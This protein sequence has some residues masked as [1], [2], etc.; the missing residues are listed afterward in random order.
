MK[1]TS[2]TLACLALAMPVQDAPAAEPAIVSHL[3]LILFENPGT[4]GDGVAFVGHRS[5]MAA[6]L[7]QGAFSVRFADR[8]ADGSNA[9]FQ[10]AMLRYAFEGAR[11]DAKLVSEDRLPG[12]VNL[13]LGNSPDGWA[14]GLSSWRQVRY[15]GLYDGVD[16]VVHGANGVFTYDLA[17]QPGVDPSVVRIRVEGADALFVDDAG[18]LIARTANGEMRQSL[19]VTWEL[20]EDGSRRPVESSF[21][22]HADGSYGFSVAADPSS[23]LLIDPGLTWSTYLGGGNQDGSGNEHGCGVDVD[24]DC[25]AYV[26]GDTL[27]L[28]F[29][30]TPGAFQTVQGGNV[31]AFVAK[32]VGKGDALLYSTFI[33]GSGGDFG[34]GIAVDQALCAYVT[35]GT[36]SANLPV[37]GGVFDT[38]YNGNGDMFVAKLTPDGTGLSYC[39]YIGG[40]DVDASLG[41]HGIEVNA[42]GEAFITGE[43]GSADYPTTVG[44]FAT[45]HGGGFRDVF[46]TKLAAD[47]S[48]LLYSTFVGGNGPGISDSGTSIALDNA[49]NAYVVGLTTSQNFPTT[50]GVVAPNPPGNGSNG[51]LFKVSPTGAA[52]SYS[53]F[54]GGTGDVA[55]SVSVEPSTGV[56]YAVGFTASTVFPTTPGAFD[57]SSNGFGDGWITVL[58]PNAA[59][60]VYSSYLGGADV[61]LGNAVDVDAKGQAY[62]SGWTQSSNFPTT[63]NAF[64]KT[65]HYNGPFPSGSAGQSGAED[66][67][68][69]RVSADGSKIEY[70]TY[71]G[72]D[73]IDVAYAINV[74]DEGS[75]YIAGGTR[76][77][78]FPTTAGAVDTTYNGVNGDQDV[79][80]ILMPAGETV[81]PA[82][83]TSSNYGAGKPGKYGVPSLTMAAEAKVGQFG[84]AMLSN[85]SE[86]SPYAILIGN[87]TQN[88]A[89]NGGTILVQ[90]FYAVVGV[91]DG[92]GNA[93]FSYVLQE[94]PNFCGTTLYAQAFVND[95]TVFL[96]SMSSGLSMTLGY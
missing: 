59:S 54:I 48:A 96:F 31:D 42:I 75:V 9:E 7:E 4:L 36:S 26:A 33:G 84:T 56:G 27:S 5:G 91:T 81:C 88:L 62:I 49:G 92:S 21:V 25:A 38:T 61:D 68:L 2:F 20:G 58:D 83:A 51:F 73:G 65:H 71:I 47:G 19:P 41:A 16:V 89:F 80:L 53:T 50:A 12:T 46:A 90:P 87:Q 17:V 77:T 74:H 70:S 14:S 37:T 60:L 94:N 18:A 6:W 23:G 43:T 82:V 55:R 64:D 67:F 69:T 86:N 79:F 52:L 63:A 93:S 85:A 66:V 15:A 78:N 45:V 28:N 8:Y 32:I 44:A 76:S 22:L 1:T 13:L 95:P 10:G 11:P 57:T 39:T 34:H 40:S 72:G 29:P 3:P 24:D 30:V 35:G